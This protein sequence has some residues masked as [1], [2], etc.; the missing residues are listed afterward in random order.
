MRLRSYLV[1]GLFLGFGILGWFTF[2]SRPQDAKTFEALVRSSDPSKREEAGGLITYCQ[3][4]RENVTKDVWL[5]Q[6]K[7]LYCHIESVDSTL[8][9]FSQGK[10][11]E[12][13]EEL[14]QMECTLQEKLFYSDDGKPMQ[15]VNY[16]RAARACYNYNTQVLTADNAQLWKYQLP[17]HTLTSVK[18]T[19]PT[20][21]EKQ[22]MWN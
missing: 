14:D 2:V 22:N 1:L 11:V 19:S 12:M 4:F 16:I 13:I 18:N 3:Q 8:F 10:Q 21:K 7:P 9:F 17:G 20:M 15:T 6:E 5:R